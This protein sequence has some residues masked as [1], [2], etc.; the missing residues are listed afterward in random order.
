MTIKQ[1]D[2]RTEMLSYGFT[3][4][5]VRDLEQCK[6]AQGI[7]IEFDLHHPTLRRLMNQRW[8]KVQLLREQD[9]DW[10]EIYKRIDDYEAA[11]EKAQERGIFGLIRYGSGAEK[12]LEKELNEGKD[13]TSRRELALVKY[14]RGASPYDRMFPNLRGN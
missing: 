10:D 2:G 14:F 7:P 4:K 1:K 13:F 12:Q 6:S 8:D 3:E 5:E 11:Q 9:W